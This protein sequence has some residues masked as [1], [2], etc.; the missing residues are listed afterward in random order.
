MNGSGDAAFSSS[1]VRRASCLPATLGVDTLLEYLQHLVHR[2]YIDAE[3]YSFVGSTAF[4]QCQRGSSAAR[5]RRVNQA[6][7]RA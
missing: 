6:T 3:N 4:L 1:Y 5:S 7:A 2:G